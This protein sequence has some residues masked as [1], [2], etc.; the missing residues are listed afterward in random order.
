MSTVKSAAAKYGF[1]QVQHMSAQPACG[2]L[3]QKCYKW[4][5]L[6]DE[7]LPVPDLFNQ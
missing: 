7:S 2:T 5:S 3:N 1:L 6:T 4:L